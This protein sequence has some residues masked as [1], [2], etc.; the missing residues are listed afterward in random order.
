M[1][2]LIPAVAP[3][4]VSST[5]STHVRPRYEA[6]SGGRPL[7]AMPLEAASTV[8]NLVRSAADSAATAGGVHHPTRLWLDLSNGESLVVAVQP[9]SREFPLPKEQHCV[10]MSVQQSRLTDEC[11]LDDD[12]CRDG[13]LGCVAVRW[14]LR[15]REGVLL[16]LFKAKAG[17]RNGCDLSSADDTGVR[18]GRL[19]LRV[20]DDVAHLLGIAHVLVADE[21]AVRLRVWGEAEPALVPLRYLRP[22]LRG[23]GYYEQSGYYAVPAAQW[24]F[25]ERHGAET[26]HAPERVAAARRCAAASLSALSAVRAAPFG[27]GRLCR[28]LES[29][30]AAA[31]AHE[32]EARGRLWPPPPKP[33]ATLLH[34]FARAVA[35]AQEAPAAG[36]V[37]AFVVACACEDEAAG[38]EAI[39]NRFGVHASS[40]V[41]YEPSLAR[42]ARRHEA[43]IDAELLGAPSLGAM[44]Q[45]LHARSRAADDGGDDDD[46]QV[47]TGLRAGALLLALVYDFYALARPRRSRRFV[48]KDYFGAGG[49]ADEAAAATAVLVPPDALESGAPIAV[50]RASHVPIIREAFYLCPGADDE[51]CEL[52]WGL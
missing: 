8:A 16:D 38:G 14:D 5:T 15:S 35:R 51:A 45:L 30:A 4:L 41:P 3:T 33:T 48:R 34:R 37:A 20:V 32:E 18:W 21:A 13:C 29:A 44:V 11:A 6:L 9:L 12:S 46:A 19:M 25:D 22:L 36:R 17:E 2:W 42:F 47:A 10:M 27:G 7:S 50:G 40:R 43:A 31:V 39:P 1:W 26:D 28:V 23:V 24:Y 49:A 52:P